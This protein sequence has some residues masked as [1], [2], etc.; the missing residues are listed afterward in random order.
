MIK[1]IW[2]R[3][4]ECLGTVTI[5]LVEA[6]SETG[7]FRHLSDY[8][9]EVVTSKIQNLWGS[10]F[11]SKSV[12]FNLYFKNAGK[13]SEKVF[14]FWDNCLWIG[15]V[16]LSPCCFSKGPLKQDFLDIYLTTFSASV[17]SEKQR[18]EGNLLFQN[19]LNLN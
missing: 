14:C 18:C 11:D 3:F 10:P 15:I 13:N 17:L 2:Y 5:F 19:V 8:D 1:V 9:F 16:K 12:T 4:K 6:S 7:L